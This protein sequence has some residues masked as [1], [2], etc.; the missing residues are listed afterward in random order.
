MEIWKLQAV[1][2]TMTALACSTYGL[3]FTLDKERWISKNWEDGPLGER[4]A[5]EVAG[6]IKRSKA[7]QF[8]GLMGKRTDNPQTMRMDRRKNKGE[9]FVGLMGRRSLKGVADSLTRID[10]AETSTANNA[11]METDKHLDTAF[12]EVFVPPIIS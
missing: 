12:K 1:A 5:S 6:L 8:Y 7:H 4:L 10:P 9:M 3:S 2:I 11:A